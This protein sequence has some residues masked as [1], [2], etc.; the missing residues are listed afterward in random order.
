M[1]AEMALACSKVLL[2]GVTILDWLFVFCDAKWR[3]G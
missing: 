1:N 3:V 2:G